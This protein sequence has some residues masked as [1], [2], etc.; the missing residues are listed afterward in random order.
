M[1]YE[2]YTG[3]YRRLSYDTRQKS[4]AKFVRSLPIVDKSCMAEMTKFVDLLARFQ[5]I[6]EVNQRMRC[7]CCRVPKYSR[8]VLFGSYEQLGKYLELQ[9]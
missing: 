7:C 5:R 3:D 4:G 6:L 9:H 8:A 2:Y 1:F